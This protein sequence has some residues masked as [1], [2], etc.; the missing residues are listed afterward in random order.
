MEIKLADP[1]NFEANG[2]INKLLSLGPLSKE[3]YVNPKGFYFVFP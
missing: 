1:L 2:L 3:I